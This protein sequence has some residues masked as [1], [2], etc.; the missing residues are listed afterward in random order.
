MA[1]DMMGSSLTNTMALAIEREN[2]A[3][4]ATRLSSTLDICLWTIMSIAYPGAR[5]MQALEEATQGR[6]TLVRRDKRL[7]IQI[8]EPSNSQ[9]TPPRYPSRPTQLQ[10]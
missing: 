5:P 6:E 3:A 2:R 8:C 9:T 7:E 1:W 10:R 4:R